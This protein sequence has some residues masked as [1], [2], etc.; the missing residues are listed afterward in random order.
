MEHTSSGLGPPLVCVRCST[1][2]RR[3]GWEFFIS[4][5]T[6]WRIN[7]ANLPRLLNFWKEVDIAYLR[8]YA[9]VLGYGD[10]PIDS[11]PSIV[12]D[13]F[14]IESMRSASLSTQLGIPRRGSSTF[15]TSLGVAGSRG[16]T[17][18]CR[19]IRNLSRSRIVSSCENISPTKSFS[20]RNAM[21][22]AGFK[23]RHVDIKSAKFS[24]P[25]TS[26]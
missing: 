8:P 11:D 3:S 22:C 15:T 12:G 14:G 4:R 10:P 24:F 1:R 9:D 13:V 21:W 17:G 2:L 7:A 26:F 19:G 16:R 6:P 20:E 5:S 25:H 18:V 23:F